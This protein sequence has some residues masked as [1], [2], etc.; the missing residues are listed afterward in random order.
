MS[1]LAFFTILIIIAIVGAVLAILFI[2]Y[3]KYYRSKVNKSYSENKPIKTIEPLVLYAGILFTITIILGIISVTSIHNLQT[4]VTNL[5]NRIDALE[6]NNDRLLNEIWDLNDNVN[7]ALNEGSIIQYIEYEVIDLETG[8]ED[9][10]NVKLTFVLTDNV[11]TSDITLVVDGG[12]GTTNHTLDNTTARQSVTLQLALHHSYTLYV[13]VDDGIDT[14]TYDFKEFNLYDYLAERFYF[15]VDQQHNSDEL[16]INYYLENQWENPSDGV[17]S[18]GLQIQNVDVVVK[19][20]NE[21]KVD[22]NYISPTMW[23][24]H[25]EIYTNQYIIDI[26]NMDLSV[27]EIHVIVTDNHGIE[28]DLIPN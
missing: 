24:S 16:T 5:N 7:T 11:G 18:N 28:Y 22:E 19:V 23:G 14:T 9:T 8:T 6:F 2:I 17:P 1:I 4:D 20:N 13:E 15:Y 26:S 25:N 10:Y 27:F 21:T 3:P 12:N